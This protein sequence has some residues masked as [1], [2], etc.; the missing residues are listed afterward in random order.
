MAEPAPLTVFISSPSDVEPER[1]VTERVCKVLG[2]RFSSHAAIRA[3]RWERE[4]LRATAHFQAEIPRAADADIVV[5]ILLR[6]DD[7]IARRRCKAA[8]DEADRYH[9]D[10]PGVACHAEA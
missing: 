5:V 6:E 8:M 4:P 7:E 10:T 2:S 1:V 9:R 3:V